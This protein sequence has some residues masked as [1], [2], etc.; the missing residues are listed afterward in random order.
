MGPLTKQLGS[1][2]SSGVDAETGGALGVW[3]LF[4]NLFF[5]EV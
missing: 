3:P 2:Q 4:L 5:I 1:K